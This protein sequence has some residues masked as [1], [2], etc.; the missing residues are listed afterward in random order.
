MTVGKCLVLAVA[1]AAVALFASVQA[2][3][4]ASFHF[5]FGPH[6]GYGSHYGYGHHYGLRHGYGYRYAHYPHYG[7]GYY[8]GYHPSYDYGRYG[9]VLDEDVLAAP[10]DDAT[11]TV[12]ASDYCREFTS[13]IIID[14]V[15][16]AA[17]GTACRQ[18]DG[19]W[20]IVD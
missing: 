15:E 6:Y 16:Q 12:D 13:T 17:Y 3:A 4:G 8:R 9:R 1:V 19:S 10:V 7:F 14:G 5:G 11:T 2:N 20:K 18:S